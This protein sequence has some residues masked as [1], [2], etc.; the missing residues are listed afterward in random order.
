MICFV[1]G[2]FVNSECFQNV[3]V[4]KKGREFGGVVIHRLLCNSFT[5][6]A[7]LRSNRAVQYVTPELK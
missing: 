5:C 6:P 7:Y 4:L 2:R 1:N 3:L